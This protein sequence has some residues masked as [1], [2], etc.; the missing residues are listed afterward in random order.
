VGWRTIVLKSIKHLPS[1]Q[2]TG[3]SVIEAQSQAQEEWVQHAAQVA[4]MTLYPKAGS[5]YM[6]ANVPGKPVVMMPYVGG[7]AMYRQPCDSV[8][9]SGYPGFTIW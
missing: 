4:Q 2:G 8:A 9:D 7:R 6:G 1:V 3:A 5:W